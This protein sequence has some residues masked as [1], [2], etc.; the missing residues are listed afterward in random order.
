MSDLF[1]GWVQPEA[2]LF[3]DVEET[4]GV[5]ADALREPDG[6]AAIPSLCCASRRPPT[7]RARR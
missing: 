1:T 2:D 5:K 7:L 3:V 4:I 6:R